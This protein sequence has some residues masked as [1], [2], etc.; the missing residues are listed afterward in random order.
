MKKILPMGIPLLMLAGIQT[1]RADILTDYNF[2]E[3]FYQVVY[4]TSHPTWNTIFTGSFTFDSTTNAISNLTGTLT[5]AMSGNTTSVGLNNQLSAV[6]DGNGGEL[7]SVFAQNS[8]DVFLGGGFATGGKTTFGNQNAYA[9]IDINLADPTAALTQAQINQLAYADCTTGGLMGSTCM[10]GWVNVSSGTPMAGGTM[11]GTYPITETI[12]AA[13]PE[14][15][16][17]ALML[18]GLGLVGFVATRRRRQDDPM[19]SFA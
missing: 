8:T 2:T 1:A 16:T 11:K 17:Y 5:Q 13:V 19:A 3:T 7:I 10:T 18:A 6:S 14:P 12:T 9:T 4:A 15:S